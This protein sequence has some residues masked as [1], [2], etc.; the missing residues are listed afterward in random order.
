ME[1][2]PPNRIN[3]PEYGSQTPLQRVVHCVTNGLWEGRS[4]QEVENEISDLLW[5]S[6][7]NMVP[8]KDGWSAF[9]RGVALYL[10]EMDGH[11]HL[12]HEEKQTLYAAARII[13]EKLT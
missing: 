5:L 8:D 7:P 12:T 4:T 10:R 11:E 1:Q 3:W 2:K 9:Y 13:D 6:D